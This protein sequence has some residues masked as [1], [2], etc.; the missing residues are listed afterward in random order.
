MPEPAGLTAVIWESLSTVMPVAAKPA[1]STC[2]APVKPEPLMTTD[3][4]PVSGPSDGLR[5]VT[6]VPAPR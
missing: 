3:V 5:F 2:V 6:T 4:P 1:N